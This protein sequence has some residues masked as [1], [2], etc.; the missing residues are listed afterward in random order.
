MLNLPTPE[1]LTQ[2]NLLMAIGSLEF[3]AKEASHD[4]P[5]KTHIS[6]DVIGS[7]LD[8]IYSALKT[9]SPF[10][11]LFVMVSIM[12]NKSDKE[13]SLSIFLY[14]ETGAAVIGCTVYRMIFKSY[15]K[16]FEVKKSIEKMLEK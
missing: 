11:K 1:N 7:Q 2:D 4:Q 8:Y 3:I 5:V 9:N 12:P 10:D 14:R 13:Y 15:N 6:V 16:A